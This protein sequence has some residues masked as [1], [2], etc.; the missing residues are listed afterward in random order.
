MMSATLSCAGSPLPLPNA[1]DVIELVKI[2]QSRMRTVSSQ[3]LTTSGYCHEHCSITACF[4]YRITLSGVQVFPFLL[5][6]HPLPSG[7]Q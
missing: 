5:D 6:V 2:H 3:Q 4:M 7:R 1:F